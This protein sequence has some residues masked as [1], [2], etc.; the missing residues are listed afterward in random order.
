MFNRSEED[1]IEVFAISLGLH[2][3]P[4]CSVIQLLGVH[5]QFNPTPG[6]SLHKGCH[7]LLPAR[8][9]NQRTWVFVTDRSV[10]G[11]TGLSR[12]RTS[13]I[14]TSVPDTNTEYPNQ[15]TWRTHQ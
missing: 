4:I 8:S 6:K 12:Q 15:C 10:K 11:F 1:L 5:V 14:S 3:T 7:V 2:Q 13:D 9:S